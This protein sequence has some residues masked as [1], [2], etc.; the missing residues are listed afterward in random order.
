MNVVLPHFVLTCSG[1]PAAQIG[2]S[3]FVEPSFAKVDR[4]GGMHPRRDYA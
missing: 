2:R 3:W 1:L 4:L